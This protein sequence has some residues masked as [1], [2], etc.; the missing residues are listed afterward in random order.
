MRP[1]PYYGM[2][3]EEVKEGFTL[4]VPLEL[5]EDFTDKFFALW[6][7]NGDGTF[8]IEPRRD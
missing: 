4:P 3:V 7:D 6:K 5:S 2:H 8:T 1:G